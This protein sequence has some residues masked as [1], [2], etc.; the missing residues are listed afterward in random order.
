MLSRPL[1][2]DE[3]QATQ[4]ALEKAASNSGK[5]VKLSLEAADAERRQARQRELQEEVGGDDVSDD[6]GHNRKVG[7]PESAWDGE[8]K[9]C[10]LC[11]K[12]FGVFTRRHHCRGCGRNACDGCS[13]HK[14][15]LPEHYG[16]NKPQRICGECHA[17]LQFQKMRK[18]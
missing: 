6:L 10:A 2:S 14:A 15:L 16:K 12:E 5:D 3:I 9:E 17:T 7:V 1:S 8:A 18:R 4:D 11:Q 13:S